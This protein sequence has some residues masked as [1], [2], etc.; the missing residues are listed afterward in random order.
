M[1]N[2][3]DEHLCHALSICHYLAGTQNYSLVYNG[4]SDKGLIAYTDSDCASDLI[5]CQSQ[6]DCFM[7][8]ADGIISWSSQAQKTIA[9]LST[10]AKYMV[11]SDCWQKVTWIQSLPSEIGIKET[12]MPICGDNQGF[13]FI[14]NNS[15]QEK[16]TK[17]IY[18]CFHYIHEQIE[19][20]II[21]ALFIV[22]SDSPRQG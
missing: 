1:A 6:T 7:Q 20:N 16:W 3:S 5:H 10:E 17:H 22:G 14:A 9:F 12:K 4:D 11:M 19:L 21:E 15:V 2:P 8:L 13:I 18:I